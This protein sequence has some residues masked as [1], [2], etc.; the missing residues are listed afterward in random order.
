[1][2][3]HPGFICE[4]LNT[5]H[6]LSSVLPSGQVDVTKQSDGP[7]AFLAPAANVASATTLPQAGAEGVQLSLRAGGCAQDSPERE[8][9]GGAFLGA[10]ARRGRSVRW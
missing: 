9:H 6:S 1:M 4:A 7:E 3:A 8:S 2:S 10:V 5:M